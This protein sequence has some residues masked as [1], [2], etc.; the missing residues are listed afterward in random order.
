MTL[1]QEMF[2]AVIGQIP[3]LKYFKGS[4]WSL[5]NKVKDE[6]FI[7]VKNEIEDYC[8]YLESSPKLD[9]SN[10]GAAR[11]AAYDLKSIFTKVEITPDLIISLKFCEEALVQ[12]YFVVGENILNTA[13]ATRRSFI[14]EGL[15]L[16][17]KSVIITVVDEP[18]Y[19]ARVYN[20]LLSRT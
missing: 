13:S 6:R 11:S 7:R 1:A 8:Y 15:K 10:P 9:R 4:L 12:H 5:V 19:K 2:N 17:A 20:E 14:E 18:E 16:I 3:V